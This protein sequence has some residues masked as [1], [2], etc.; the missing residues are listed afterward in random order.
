MCSL[1]TEWVHLLYN[2]LPSYR[3][4]LWLQNV[5]SDYRMCSLT[6]DCDLLLQIVIWLSNV[7]SAS[8]RSSPSPN[9]CHGLSSIQHTT[10]YTL[11]PTTYTLH[12]TPYTL[13]PTPYIPPQD[14]YI[15]A[16]TY[17]YVRT[18]SEVYVCVYTPPHEHTHTHTHT[19]THLTFMQVVEVQT[20]R[21][22]IVEVEK[23]RMCSLRIESV[24]LLQSR[25]S[26]RQSLKMKGWECVLLG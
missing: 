4:D 18:D 3:C 25:L 1:T 8:R 11:H 14:P 16:Q 17:V 24:L 22:K 2:V 7:F 19:H 13:H 23:V 10:P 5:F 20:V 6:T 15:H 21:E 12:P 26:E 9:K